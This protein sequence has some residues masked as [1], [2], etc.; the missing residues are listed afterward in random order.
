MKLL[1]KFRMQKRPGLIFGM[2]GFAVFFITLM[3][4][5]AIAYFQ[6]AT[7][8]QIEYTYRTNENL[9]AAYAAHTAQ[10]LKDIE[11]VLRIISMEHRRSGRHFDLQ[12]FAQEI[13]LNTDFIL[14]LYIVDAKGIV[15]KASQTNFI[16]RSYADREHFRV[17]VDNYSDQLYSGR[18]VLGRNTKAEVIPLSLRISGPHGEFLGTAL[19]GVNPLHFV[20]LYQKANL[21][22]KGAVSF[23]GL[24][25]FIRAR[26]TAG[27][28]GV[29]QD[30]RK[31]PMIKA[32]QDQDSGRIFFTAVTDKVSRY[33]S[34]QRVQGYPLSI[35]VGQDEDEA[36]AEVT[37][38][39]HA[40]LLVGIIITLLMIAATVLLVRGVAREQRV[41]NTLQ[42]RSTDLL[43]AKEEA[44]RANT[45][46]SEFLSSM[47]HELRT[48]MN[49]ILGYSQLMVYD[50]TFPLNHKDNVREILK[51]GGH[52]LE[53]INE[54][55]DLAKIESGHID[56]SIEPVE[57]CPIFNECLSLIT[58]L[59][60]QRGIKITHSC[61]KG[62][63]VGADRTR[64]KQVLLNLLSNA[65]KYNRDNG[66]VTLE[67]KIAG[68][69][70]L[71]IF[72][73]DTGNG[74]PAARIK[75]LFHPF[76]RLDAANSNIEGTGIGLTIARRIVEMMGGTVDLESEVGVGSTF[77]IDLPLSTTM[78]SEYKNDEADSATQVPEQNIQ[79]TVLYIEDN[80]SNMRLVAQILSNRK[81]L[82]LLTAN[83]A[84]W[85]IELAQ[86]Y[87]PDLIL[88]DIN[89][90][91]MN[92]YQVLEL[93][94]SD[95]NLQAI[96][97]IALTANA[98]P[99][100][101]E[102]GMAAGFTDYLT[103]PID[104]SKF[105]AILDRC[106]PARAEKN[107]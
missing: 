103:K 93:L 62:M 13:H 88:L 1:S 90:P 56:L 73:R 23:F 9:A 55:L 91:G 53:L 39:A 94:K 27:E 102:R 44:E 74:I 32:A 28:V 24:D 8:R 26:I 59:A 96:P 47:S 101:I 76:S 4:I 42:N 50:N 100:D 61:L 41:R 84:A 78:E 3:W 31:A 51:A 54:V 104:V 68:T 80:P 107:S 40:A 98:M 12:A 89:M 10:A 48:P 60:E 21:G 106:L 2:V 65:I 58:P 45:A 97:V 46:K 17:H 63:A 67:A 69:E 7:Q 37:G 16:G 57:I 82:Q 11:G 34:F 25:G 75:E 79:R 18:P 5:A 43:L 77:W 71:R 30:V 14:A 19:A 33:Y 83:T 36:L 52:L 6:Y 87:R 85:G 105:F 15:V 72:V 92:G 70:R 29:G 35:A 86:S 64:L 66:S 20:N 49:A 38:I 22:S 99:R 95:A 81:H